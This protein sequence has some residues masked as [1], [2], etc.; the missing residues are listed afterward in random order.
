MSLRE[1][2][3]NLSQTISSPSNIPD[4]LEFARE[5]A[6]NEEKDRQWYSLFVKPIKTFKT[7]KHK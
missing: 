1:T 5:T 7:F 4:L 6:I 3:L 2:F